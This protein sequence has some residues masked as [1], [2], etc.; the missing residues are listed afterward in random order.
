MHNLST[1]MNFI[2]KCPKDH[3]GISLYTD[4]MC[5][6]LFKNIK[7]SKKMAERVAES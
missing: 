3:I 4:I 7:K 2:G 1:F 5:Y 6:C